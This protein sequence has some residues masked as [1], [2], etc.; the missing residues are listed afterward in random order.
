MSMI[1]TDMVKAAYDAL[2]S[3]DRDRAAQYWAEDLTWIV[4][5]THQLAGLYTSLDGFLGFMAQVDKLSGGS[6]TMNNELIL[7]GDDWSL[8]VSNNTASRST[9]APGSRSPY[10]YL[11]IGVAHVLK[12]R[13]GKIIDGRAGIFG[14]GTARFNMF[15]SQVAPD[16]SRV[17]V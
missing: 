15:W 11:E 8:D 10:D 1:T 7:V 4:P 14:D 12:W 9:A 17:G 6:F 3:G 13:N 5:G 2:V 16:G